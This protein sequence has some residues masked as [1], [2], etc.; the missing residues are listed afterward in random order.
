MGRLTYCYPYKQCLH[1]G[2]V[3]SQKREDVWVVRYVDEDREGIFGYRLCT[4][5]RQGLLFSR[6][7]S[8]HRVGGSQRSP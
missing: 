4:P 8:E 1:E 2:I 3:L 7:S 6:R 5:S